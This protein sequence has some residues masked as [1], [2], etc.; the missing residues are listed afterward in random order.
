MTRYH[1][2]VCSTRLCTPRD[3]ADVLRILDAVQH[4]EQRGWTR[5]IEQVVQRQRCAGVEI[6]RNPLVMLRVRDVIEP[7]P[8]YLLDEDVA[9]LGVLEDLGQPRLRT[10]RTR[11]D[12]LAC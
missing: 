3:R 5:L 7:L 9:C 8:G 11:N 2:A 12:D 4:H 10:D 1:D 6:S